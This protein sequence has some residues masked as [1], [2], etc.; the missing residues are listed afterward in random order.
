[1]ASI[2]LG[3][4]GLD[5]KTDGFVLSFN[6]PDNCTYTITVDQNNITVVT[7]TLPEGKDPSPDFSFYTEPLECDTAGFL[8]VDFILPEEGLGSAPGEPGTTRK[9]RMSVSALL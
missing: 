7:V 3:N 6:I 9:P 1:M 8:E 4:Y 5:Y 2:F